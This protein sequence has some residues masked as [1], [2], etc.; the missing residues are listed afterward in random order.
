[1]WNWVCVYGIP[2]D[3]LR[4]HVSIAS[5]ETLSR[6]CGAMSKK[7]FPSVSQSWGMGSW[8][9]GYGV[10]GNGVWARRE[11]SSNGV[12]ESCACVKWWGMEYGNMG[13]R[14]CE[15]WGMYV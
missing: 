15:E 12:V 3:M 6:F 13:V 1:M 4:Y 2:A 5:V 8:G 11:W 10:A 14:G 9:T 7:V